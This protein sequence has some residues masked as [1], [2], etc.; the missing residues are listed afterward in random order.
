MGIIKGILTRKRIREGSKIIDLVITPDKKRQVYLEY[1]LRKKNKKNKIMNISLISEI[2]VEY[3][4]IA[5]EKTGI[6]NTL[7][8]NKIKVL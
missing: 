5:I 3:E 6:G 4:E 7:I 8:I 1:H 2:E